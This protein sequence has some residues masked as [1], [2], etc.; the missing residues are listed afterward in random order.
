MELIKHKNENEGIKILTTED[1]GV[2][3]SCG[4]LAKLLGYRNTKKAIKKHM[5]E[6]D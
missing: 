5:A 6:D 2:Y 1:G 4:Q 3:L